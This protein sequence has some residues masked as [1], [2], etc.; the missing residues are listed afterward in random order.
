MNQGKE[1]QYSFTFDRL[2]LS[3][4]FLTA[5]YPF[6]ELT[7]INALP[8]LGYVLSERAPI[9]P[10]GGRIAIRGEIAAKGDI[11]IMLNSD[12]R[13]LELIGRDIGSLLDEFGNLE[14]I[15]LDKFGLD[16]RQNAYF[17]E[18]LA[19]VSVAGKQSP[20]Q[21]LGRRLESLELLKE[22]GGILKHPVTNFG[23]RLAP[24]DTEPNSADWFDIRIEPEVLRPRSH[25]SI[26]IVYRQRER[27]KVFSFGQTLL[28]M[29][30][31][32]II[33]LEGA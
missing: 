31:H 2:S 1:S 14:K 27:D 29:L 21:S 5:L 28:Q 8:E 11:R 23:M 22:L 17:Y 20:L 13:T 24:P 18:L 6:D 12:L 3:V 26:L 25:Y 15:L 19:D 30:E 9:P 10:F 7:F 4:R 16:A 33:C 32:L